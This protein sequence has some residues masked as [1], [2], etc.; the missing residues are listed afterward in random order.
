MISSSMLRAVG[1]S[2][3][4]AAQA[5]GAG[6]L[7]F[8][9]LKGALLTRPDAAFSALPPAADVR[10]RKSRA[11][12]GVAI[13]I[14]RVLLKR[15]P[16]AEALAA[17]APLIEAGAV[18]FLARLLADMNADSLERGSTEA[19]AM[20]VRDWLDRFFTATSEVVEVSE[21]RVV[22]HVHACALVR[23]VTAAGHPELAPLF[24]RGDLTF[25]GLR[26]I[27]L[28]RPVTIARGDAHCRFE[29]SRAQSRTR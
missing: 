24:C 25:F 20:R 26:D 7:V 15:L 5:A 22:F 3:T 23:L 1:T 16:R 18:A 13:N 11:Q 9:L 19:R 21:A 6:P 4:S 27:K 17:M 12:A 28:E 8:A 29:L 10:E 2:I 14:Y